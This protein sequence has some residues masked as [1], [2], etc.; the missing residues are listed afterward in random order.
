MFK[1][2]PFGIY[3]YGKLED[4]ENIDE[5]NLYD[6][7]KKLISEA[8]IDIFISGDIEEEKV[9]DDIV[10]NKN[11]EKLNE[12]TPIYNMQ[13][14]PIQ[15]HETPQEIKETA[16][17]TQGNLCIG[18][19]IE[20]NNKKERYVAIVYNA[21]FGGFSTSK[22]FQIVREKHS[23]AYT[24]SSNYL[25]HKNVIF[26]R[27]GIEIENYEKTMNIIKEQIEDMKKGNFTDEDIQNGKVRYTLYSKND[28][29]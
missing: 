14:V 9:I 19:E 6:Y 4:I 25:R 3:K 15:K 16:D 7:Y 28:T 27:C 2:T 26:I 5:K 18:L 10:R 22:L 24:A 1:G 8:K 17:V 23:L 21:I 12:R 11:I 29:R 13:N 20:E